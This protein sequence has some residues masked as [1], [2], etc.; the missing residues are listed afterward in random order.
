[1]NEHSRIHS[2]DC[3]RLIMAFLVVC[4]HVPFNGKVGDVF[5]TF[6]KTAVPFFL[7]VC[8]YMLYRDDSQLMMKRLI[9]QAKRIGIFYALSTAFYVAVNIISIRI[10]YRNFASVKMLYGPGTVKNFLL[11]NYWMYA[12]HL[13]FLGSLFYALLIMILLNK[14]KLLK[15]VVFF[16]PLLIA[17][18]VILSH[19]GIGQW[20]QLRN[21]VLVGLSYT[22]TGMLIRR[23]EEKILSIKFI[24]AILSAAFVVTC[25][26]AIVEL[27]SYKEGVGVPFVSCEIMTFVL[28][29]LCL[30]LRNFGEGTLME[31]LGRECALPVYILH[32]AVMIFLFFVIPERV[33]LINKFGAVTVFVV[34]T[35]IAALYEKVKHLIIKPK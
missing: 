9:K 7:A 14:L 22:M 17:C 2:I 35:V 3:M 28:L 33:G 31:K 20:Y 25:I 32:I 30:K 29:L 10:E 19:M 21:A 11:Y 5:I 13:W 23:F 27:N 8:G 18:Y 12:E 4:I 15:K 34:T 16:G 1:M 6:G 26:T 24:T